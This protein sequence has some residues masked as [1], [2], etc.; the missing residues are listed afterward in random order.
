MAFTWTA[1]STSGAPR[2]TL[3]LSPKLE[4]GAYTLQ[5][6]DLLPLCQVL[7]ER[8][9]RACQTRIGDL[10]EKVPLEASLARKFSNLA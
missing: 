5:A 10:D 8:A 2:L 1:W 6:L 4:E 9:F 7:C 3:G